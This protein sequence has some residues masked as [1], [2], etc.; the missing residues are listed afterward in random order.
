VK[1]EEERKA[2]RKEQEK[3][4]QRN[5]RRENKT[6]TIINTQRKKEKYRLGPPLAAWEDAFSHRRPQVKPSPLTFVF[7]GFIFL[8]CRTCILHGHINI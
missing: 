2:E 3:K 6:K 4:K 1:G 5:K 8:A 7:S